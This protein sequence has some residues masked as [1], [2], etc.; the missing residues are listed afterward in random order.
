MEK[1]PFEGLPNTPPR[2]IY[3]HDYDSLDT[4]PAYKNLPFIGKYRLGSFMWAFAFYN[5]TV[6]RISLN[7]YYS[8]MLFLGK[9]FPYIAIWR[10]GISDA[11]VNMFK[12]DPLDNT[13]P[14]PNSE[15]YKTQITKTWY[16]NILDILW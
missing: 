4:V 7:F 5:N 12:E 3:F 16:R 14:K 10:Y 13:I 9:Y 11:F 6:G 8:F 15:Y 1:Y 2:N